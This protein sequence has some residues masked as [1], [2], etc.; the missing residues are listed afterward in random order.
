MLASI[1]L[2][3]ARSTRSDRSCLSRGSNDRENDLPAHVSM[4]YLLQGKSGLLERIDVVDDHLELSG[5]DVARN[6]P[7]Q[8]SFRRSTVPQ[9]A[10]K[11][12]PI[13]SDTLSSR[14]NQRYEAGLSCWI[15][16]NR[17]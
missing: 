6:A 11:A 12:A 15:I 7:Q 9:R 5:I 13:D 2:A 10:Q 3:V 16:S 1:R 14:G 4:F 8:F 17:S